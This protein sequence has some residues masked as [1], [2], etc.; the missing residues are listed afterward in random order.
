MNLILHAKNKYK[1]IDQTFFLLW[2]DNFK[3][4]AIGSGAEPWTPVVAFVLPSEFMHTV[5]ILDV[6]IDFKKLSVNLLRIVN[7]LIVFNSWISDF[8]SH[9][10]HVPMGYKL[11]KNKIPG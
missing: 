10:N 2:K 11:G 3:Y 7:T 6:K 8:Y 9:S 5:Y 1:N 4:P